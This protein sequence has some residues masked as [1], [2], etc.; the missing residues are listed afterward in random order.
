MKYLGLIS[1]GKVSATVQKTEGMKTISVNDECCRITC[2]ALRG[3]EAVAEEEATLLMQQYYDQWAQRY[4]KARFAFK[5]L[6]RTPYGLIHWKFV[7]EEINDRVSLRISLDNHFKI[8]YDKPCTWRTD[9]GKA[10]A[11]SSLEDA[12]RIYKMVLSKM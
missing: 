10:T 4:I 5:Q 7:I 12:I 8:T 2:E 9:R 11:V 1:V 3:E 6:G